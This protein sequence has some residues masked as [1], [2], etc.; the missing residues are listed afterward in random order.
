MS[1]K[2]AAVQ[3]SPIAGDALRVGDVFLPKVGRRMHV[4]RI[5][6]GTRPGYP[7]QPILIAHGPVTF[8]NDERTHPNWVESYYGHD[9]VVVER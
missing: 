8:A 7:M 6:L 5:T 3:V 4:E 2:E 9:W 1:D